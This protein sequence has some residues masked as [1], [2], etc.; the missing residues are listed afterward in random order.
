MGCF[1]GGGCGGWWLTVFIISRGGRREY[2]MVEPLDFGTNRAL[3]TTKITLTPWE[4]T[5]EE[6][7][8]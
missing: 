1:G 7:W 6:G 3:T 4:A 5:M 8:W 2:W